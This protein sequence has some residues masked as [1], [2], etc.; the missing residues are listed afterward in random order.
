[1]LQAFFRLAIVS[2]ILMSSTSAHA[3]E[4]L[5]YALQNLFAT[6]QMLF[7]LYRERIAAAGFNL[8]NANGKSAEQS[9]EHL[10]FHFL[11]RFPGD[12]VNAWPD[13]PGVHADFGELFKLVSGPEG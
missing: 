12:G 5:G 4:T 2:L 6:V 8:L 3:D 11:P 13:V 1:M 7:D 10:H 9:V